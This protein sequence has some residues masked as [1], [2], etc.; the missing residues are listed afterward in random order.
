MRAEA[1]ERILKFAFIDFEFNGMRERS[2]RLV[3]MSAT[4]TEDA[5]VRRR[6][7]FWLYDYGEEYKRLQNYLKDLISKDFILVAYALEAE[8]RSLLTLFSNDRAV[9]EGFRGV[10]LYLEYRNLLNHNYAFQY[11]EQYIDGRIITT[12]PPP[13]KFD[14]VESMDEDELH[15][16]PSYSLAAAS[17]KLLR[18]KIDTDEKDAVRKMIYLAPEGCE[19][20]GPEHTQ[21]LL[22][23]KTR[24]MEYNRADVALLPQLLSKFHDYHRLKMISTEKFMGS[25]LKRGE[26]AI[27]TAKMTELGYPVNMEKIKKFMGNVKEILNSATEEV[28]DNPPQS[29]VHQETPWAAFRKDKKT[30]A[31]ICNTKIIE[32]WV[33]EQIKTGKVGRWRQT[34]GGKKGVKKNSISKDA[35]GDWFDTTSEGFPG[36]YCRFLKTKQSLNGFVSGNG[37]R[38]V[39]T[40]FVGKDSR[41]RP[42][43]GIYGSQASRS[44]PGAVGFI[45][46]KAHWMRNFIESAPGRAMAGID[47]SSEEFLIA[48]IIS[49]DFKMMEAYA[50]GDPYLAFGKDAKLLPPD[51][52]KK[53]HALQREMLKATVLGVSY[54]MTANG[55]APRISR[56]IKKPFSVDDAQKLITKFYDTYGHYADWKQEIIREYRNEGFIQLSDGWTMWGDNDNLRSV[57]NCPIQGEGAVIMREAVS[58]GQARDLDIVFTLHDALYEEYP[59]FETGYIS[60]LMDCMESAFEKVM[61]K[62][63]KTVPIRLEGESW[64]RDY[65]DKKPEPLQGVTFLHEYSDAKGEADLARYRKFFT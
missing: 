33:D 4:L 57:G 2:L 15:H 52:T 36:A 29:W 23:N 13:P 3:S 25:A 40:D 59:S 24:I 56:V 6:D 19:I 10:D 34:D 63:G 35:F 42:N 41:A 58:L 47:Y 46:L 5:V 62:F 54:D 12:T 20:N 16:K 32:A 48:A 50:S 37:K 28:M 17:F 14:R 26:F 49:Q 22:E 61:S 51:A 9:L 11:G 43:F 21:L 27:A 53:S 44:Q 7:D 45:P 31:W 18:K 65:L 60:V 38:G 1:E 64:S 55:L 39:F 30:Q 8:A